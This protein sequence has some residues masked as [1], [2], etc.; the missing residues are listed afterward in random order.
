MSQER[1]DH[2]LAMV[3]PLIAKQNSRFRKAITS[4]ERLALTLRFLATGE[5]QISLTYLF[6]MGRNTVSKLLSETC[7]AIYHALAPEY[8]SSS[9][10]V[11]DWKNISKEFSKIWNLPH[12]LGAIDG[13]HIRIECPKNSGTLYHNYKGFFSLV[14]LAVCDAPYCFH[15]FDVGQYGRNNDAGVLARSCIGKRFRK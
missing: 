5:S 10:T 9:R 6:R 8:L 7:D 2:Q 11:A 1:Y 13:K 15:L 14:L 3:H 4:S 12:V